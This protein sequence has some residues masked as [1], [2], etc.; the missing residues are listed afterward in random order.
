MRMQS[1][2]MV[3]LVCGL[4][5]LSAAWVARA[6]LE[7]S[8]CPALV[9]QALTIVADNCDALSRNAACYGYNRVNSTF[10]QTQ[11]DTFFSSPSDRADLAT[12][13]S[14]VTQPLNEATA[15]WGIAVINAQ[16]NLPETLP[17]QGVVFILLGDVQVENAVPPEESRPAARLTAQTL[18]EANL[19]SA[20]GLN[21]SVIGSLPAGTDIIL[22]ARSQVGEW[23][24]VVTSGSP[25]WISVDLISTP[26][27]LASLPTV[28]TL[29]RAPMQA[30][31]FNTGVGAR[32]CNAVPPSLL[33]VQG[34]RGITVDLTANGADI[35]LGST[36]A[37][38]RLQG[39]LVQLMVID[40][41]VQLEGLVVPAGYTVTTPTDE[42]GQVIPFGWSSFR[43]LTEGELDELL[44]LENIPVNLLHYPIV[45]PRLRIP[46][47]AT[48][49][50]AGLAQ[51][52][53]FATLSPRE[54]M[55]YGPETFYWT[56]TP[57]ATSYRL[58]V[59]N[60]DSGAPP[61]SF[62]GTNL[63]SLTADLS[64]G[65]VGFGYRFAWNV[66][67]LFNGEVACA[68]EQ[69]VTLRESPPITCYD[70]LTIV[71]LNGSPYTGAYNIFVNNDN[72]TGTDCP[73]LIYGN[74][75]ANILLGG[76][77]D[78][79]IQ[80]FGGN[81]TLN[82]QGGNDTLLGDG[83]DDILHGEDGDD[84][85][86]GGAGNDQ[87]YGGTGSDNVEGGAGVDQ[88]FGGWDNTT[89]CQNRDDDGSDTV[90]DSGGDNGDQVQG[91]NQNFICGSGDDGN[92]TV[93]DT[94]GNGDAVYGGNGAGGGA[95]L[96][97]DGN[98]VV[99]DLGGDNDFVFGGNGNGNPLS[100]GDDGSDIITAVGN[101]DVVAGGNNNQA[102][103]TGNDNI[104]GGSDVINTTDGDATDQVFGG[105]WNTGAGGDSV[106][107]ICNTDPLD[108][109]VG[110]CP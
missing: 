57:G 103:G 36:I 86:N 12:L 58:N 89:G 38:R 23:G 7:A 82:G 30:F 77:G 52:S 99:S 8:E 91:G 104:D 41:A 67:A 78:D 37:M 109:V 6:Q 14:I 106:T 42:N 10:F 81:D 3:V 105:N 83:G 61:V 19:R 50:G 48:L 79:T 107:D 45:I 85:L 34:P 87:N 74:N 16:A 63:T 60:L 75:N 43:A 15:E 54:G 56:D 4:L 44:P 70:Y 26:E 62:E 5:L 33:V 25:G 53:G 22:D 20:P 47:S 73:E 90:I 96:G 84:S 31:S 71:V 39:S 64:I 98:D 69:V 95:T 11:E 66:E 9:E 108:A 46:T 55:N 94:G 18:T 24:R 32:A 88:V 92:D 68:T 21:A 93:T 1:L 17:G 2:F 80:G 97:N 59:F 51:C 29:P 40:G 101:N 28:E 49:P 13:Q 35:R 102:G 72:Y 110:N 65:T 76:G 100:V 27:Q